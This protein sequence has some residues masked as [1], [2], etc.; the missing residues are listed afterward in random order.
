MDDKCVRNLLNKV[1][2]ITNKNEI[3]SIYMKHFLAG[4]MKLCQVEENLRMKCFYKMVPHSTHK[5]H[6]K[7]V[8]TTDKYI[9]LV[10]FGRSDNFNVG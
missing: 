5:H 6:P 4:T 3:V 2:F 8:Q 10:E 7:S 9:I 1:H